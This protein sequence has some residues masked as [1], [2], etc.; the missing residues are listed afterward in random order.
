[1]KYFMRLA[2]IGFAY[3]GKIRRQKAQGKMERAGS[4]T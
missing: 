3:S 2:A 4:A 1:L